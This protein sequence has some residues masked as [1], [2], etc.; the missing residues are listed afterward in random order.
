VAELGPGSVLHD[1]YT[2]L[3]PL[4]RGGMGVVWKARH[5]RLPR[6]VAI[7]ILNEA[8]YQSEEVLQRFR[9]EAE[10]TSQLGHPHIVQVFDFNVLDDGRAYLV[11]EMLEGES[12]RERLDRGPLPE[13]DAATVVQ[14]V[15]SALSRVHREGI[16]HRDLKP[17]NIFLC[18]TEDGTTFAKVLDFGISKVHGSMTVVTQDTQLLG[19]PRYMSPEQARGENTTLDASTDQFA[20]AAIAY[21]MV[22]GQPAFDGSSIPAVL[23]KVAAEDPTPVEE[24]AQS[25]PAPITEAIQRGLAKEKSERFES[26]S[27]FVQAFSSV[28]PPPPFAPRTPPPVA[29]PPP[30]ASPPPPEATT[31]SSNRTVG[32]GVGVAALAF[33]AVGLWQWNRPSEVA[34]EP[35]AAAGAG[36]AV[37]LAEGNASTGRRPDGGI[38]ATA[39]GPTEGV[40][41]TSVAVAGPDAGVSASVDAGET[42]SRVDLG[43]G[44]S[45]VGP[46]PGLDAGRADGGPPRPPRPPPVVRS[47][48]RPEVSATRDAVRAGRYRRALMVGRRGLR[49]K[50]GR[51][52]YVWMAAAYCGLKD[53][54]GAKA[55]T[56]KLRGRQ[57]QRAVAECS[58]LGVDLN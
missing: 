48:P 6:P 22:T 5:T 23:L 26:M 45:D 56:R 39:G 14:Q 31:P 2:L 35:L 30:P 41:T 17:E 20:L 29:P 21:E 28:G 9:R 24:L 52:I 50:A 19:T 25:V 46:S 34:V 33:A 12:L 16:V 54:G 40:E 42:S 8:A 32:L 38:V 55:M 27:E 10:V 57:R 18:A 44:T 13:T 11:M 4:G 51:E 15:G 47:G 3:E 7:K 43:P 49:M 36:S 53:I 58:R 37:P 1:T